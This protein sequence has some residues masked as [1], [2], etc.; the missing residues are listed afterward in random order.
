MKT[1]LAI[2]GRCF[3][4][5]F[6]H[7]EATSAIIRNH[8]PAQSAAQQPEGHEWVPRRPDE[9]TRRRATRALRTVP[10]HVEVANRIATALA[11]LIVHKPTDVLLADAFRGFDAD[12]LPSARPHPA[13]SGIGGRVE[14][15][16]T[17]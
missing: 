2:R 5:W 6:P 16:A 10:L 12:E 13:A 4:R 17:R 9:G 3:F 11:E 8:P 7:E 1:G 15:G 14:R